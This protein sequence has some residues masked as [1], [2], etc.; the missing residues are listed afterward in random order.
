MKEKDDNLVSGLFETIFLLFNDGAKNMI[1][2]IC[3]LE[4]S[5]PTNS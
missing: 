2:E 4:F 1:S 5:N 3:M